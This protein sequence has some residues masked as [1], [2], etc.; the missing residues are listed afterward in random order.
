M[1]EKVREV[2]RGVEYREDAVG[3]REEAVAR[4]SCSVVSCSVVWECGPRSG[5]E[6]SPNAN[7][8]VARGGSR[9]NTFHKSGFLSS[10]VRQKTSL[11]GQFDRFFSFRP[12]VRL[13]PRIDTKTSPG[14]GAENENRSCTA[15]R[16]GRVN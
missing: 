16:D 1:D 3:R 12:C 9:S 14:L 10:R 2:Q 11:M 6:A 8:D 7:I 4:R 15:P 5:A 13:F